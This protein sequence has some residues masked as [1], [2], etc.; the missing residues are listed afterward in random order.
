MKYLFTVI[1]CMISSIIISQIA[2]SGPG[3]IK[4][5]VG[6]NIQSEATGITTTVDYG[7]GENISIGLRGTYLL[8]VDEYS[9]LN[10][11]TIDNGDG[12]GTIVFFEDPKFTDRFDLRARFNAH[13]SNVL[14]ISEAFDLYPGLDL[15][16]K[17]F[18]THVGARYFFTDGIG[19]FTELNLPIARYKNDDDYE[20]QQTLRKELNNQFNI[21][22][23]ASF[24][25]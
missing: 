15:G 3:D 20:I 16:L 12:S 7:L 5:G 9:N 14:N 24:N 21:T 18:G 13:L 17:N 6:A 23:G 1:T 10:A 22:I 11:F 19:V 25:I 4:F 2:Y 8:G